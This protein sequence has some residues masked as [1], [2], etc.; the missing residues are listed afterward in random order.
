MMYLHFLQICSG[1]EM[2]M[3]FLVHNQIYTAWICSDGGRICN[4]TVCHFGIKTIE[5][6][7]VKQKPTQAK[8]QALSP[9][10]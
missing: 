10:A 5:L 8:L 9:F 4:L 2:N 3:K 7:A 6:K 1:L